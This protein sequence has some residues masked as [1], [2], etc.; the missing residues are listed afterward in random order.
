MQRDCSA[1]RAV[2]ENDTLRLLVLEKLPRSFWYAAGLTC[3]GFWKT[4]CE[5]APPPRPVRFR[6][7]RADYLSSESLW[8]WGF[9]DELKRESEPSFRDKV[10]GCWGLSLVEGGGSVDAVAWVLS[11]EVGGCTLRDDRICSLPAVAVR[12]GRVDLLRWFFPEDV[13]QRSG[14]WRFQFC[15][16]LCHAAAEVGRVEMLRRLR[17]YRP[18]PCPWGENTCRAAASGGHLTT[19]QWLRAHDCPW[20]QTTCHEAAENGDLAMLRWVR[21][22]TPPCPWTERTCAKA[23]ENGHLATLQ[24]LRRQNP[25]CPW[26]REVCVEAALQERVD[27]M[28]WI[29]EQNPLWEWEAHWLALIGEGNPN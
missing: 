8:R 29:R 3:K 10:V 13:S 11:H 20:D 27:V 22:Q 1:V 18:S 21:A 16:A 17:A 26:D 14:V 9:C 15:A 2:L 12:R 23:A 24:W 6:S 4:V 5:M 19:L 28:R 7:V 25:P